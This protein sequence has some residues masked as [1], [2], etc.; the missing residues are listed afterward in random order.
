MK[1]PLLYSLVLLAEWL[2]ATSISYTVVEMQLPFLAPAVGPS[3]ISL[4]C[5]RRESG[6]SRDHPSGRVCRDSSR[7]QQQLC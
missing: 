5:R 2:A 4:L 6:K 7:R 3:S 1:L